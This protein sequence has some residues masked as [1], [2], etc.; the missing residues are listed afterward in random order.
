MAR[1][2]TIL[3]F[4]LEL[5]ILLSGCGGGTSGSGLRTYY[6]KV[7]G[8]DGAPISGVA[9][10]IENTG[11]SALTDSAGNFSISSPK[12]SNEV[13]FLFN[14]PDFSNRFSLKTH[15][16]RAAR[17]YLD[18]LVDAETQNLQVSQVS[19]HAWF[20]G[21][22]DHY[23]ENRE[24]LRQANQV[25][26]GTVCSLNVKVQGDGKRLANI[27]VELQYAG[28]EPGAEWTTI[29]LAYTGSGRHAGAAEI[30]FEYLNSPEYCRYRAFVNVA[31]R[32]QLSVEYPIESY[33]EQR[34]RQD[35]RPVTGD[36]KNAS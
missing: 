35:K 17:I 19:L 25:P 26:P 10:T 23:F 4:I 7:S 32:N 34:F 9:V 12:I 1:K 30:N 33:E 21:L 2:V 22:C 24:V 14:S 18:V 16:R 27:P 20:A 15:S 11:D 36:R 3:I 31:D 13:L 8:N 29:A 6:G 28:C 5:V